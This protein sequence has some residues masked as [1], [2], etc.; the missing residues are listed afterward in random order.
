MRLARVLLDKEVLES[1][2]K[3][4]FTQ[5]SGYKITSNAPKDLEVLGF[6]TNP[7]IPFTFEAYVKSETFD[8]I[9]DG[10]V[11]PLIKAFV[12]TAEKVEQ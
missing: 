1:L 5:R 7:K 12:Y 3:A 6:E 2:I 10:E 11:P 4:E 9:E 8:E